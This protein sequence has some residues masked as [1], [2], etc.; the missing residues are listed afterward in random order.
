MSAATIDRVLAPQR[1]RCGRQR[2]RSGSATTIRRSIPVRTF[3]DWNDPGPG[4]IEADLV[5]HCGPVASGSFTQTLVLTD[6][7]TG[8]T[9]FAP[10]L[11]REQHLVIE[12]LGEIRRRLPFPLLGFDVDNDSVFMNET[13]HDYCRAENIELTRRRP[14]RKN[15][16]AH[17]E[18]KR[19]ARSC[20]GW[21][22]IAVVRA[23]RQ[24]GNWPSCTSAR[25][26]S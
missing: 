12:V 11:V 6:I 25:G 8:W 16:Q 20:D 1:K 4:F 26:C 18:Q 9:D 2:R 22:V 5:S 19:S 24:R 7:A 14:Y 23:S 17:V 21:S 10:V 3:S 15:D 13:V